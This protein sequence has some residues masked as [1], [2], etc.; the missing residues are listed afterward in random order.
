MRHY[1]GDP[2]NPDSPL[3]FTEL[4]IVAW[5]LDGGFVLLSLY[6]VALLRTAA[7]DFQLA[8][9]TRNPKLRAWAAVIFSVNAGTVA[10]VFGFTPFTTQI[11]LQYWF[12][13]GAL[14]GAAQANAWGRHS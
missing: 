7:H 2:L 13:A 12:L 6:S 14:H 10:L 4:Q 5:I 11:G 8:R 1:F 9:V 3:I